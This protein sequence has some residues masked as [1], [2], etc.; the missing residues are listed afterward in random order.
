[1]H[2][3]DSALVQIGNILFPS[4]PAYEQYQLIHN[5]RQSEGY[6]RVTAHFP[7]TGTQPDS[8]PPGMSGS[9]T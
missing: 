1:M 9:R 2:A 6:G 8:A 4:F 3:C 5:N 7:E